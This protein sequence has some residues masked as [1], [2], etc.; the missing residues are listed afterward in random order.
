M[1]RKKRLKLTKEHKRKISKGLKGITFSV[2]HRQRI[3]ESHKGKKQSLE[4]IAKRVAS[5]KGYRHSEETKRKIALGNL[6]KKMSLESKMKMIKN[7]AHIRYWLGKKRPDISGNK[8]HK[9]RGESIGYCGIHD[10][11]ALKYGKAD[12]CENSKC[13][14]KSKL[15]DWAKK[16]TVKYERK[17][18]NFWML[19]KSCH[20]KYDYTAER[21]KKISE[22]M[23]QKWRLWKRDKSGKFTSWCFKQ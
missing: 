16:R 10:W 22:T 3:S 6:G 1:I 8:N 12:R 14:G 19:C 13:E 5:R 21:G 17:R 4:L 9:W 7:H 18:K 2:F 15:F 23:K 20:Q 11:L